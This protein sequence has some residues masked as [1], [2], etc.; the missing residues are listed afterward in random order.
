MAPLSGD[1]YYPDMTADQ[2]ENLLLLLVV[3]L[4]GL[5]LLWYVLPRPKAAMGLFLFGIAFVPVW[6]GGN[7]STLVTPHIALAGVC[8]LALL[9]GG[10]NDPRG[11]FLATGAGL[12]LRSFDLTL[13]VLA[14][15]AVGCYVIG[16][17]DLGQVYLIAVWGLM[18]L[19]GRLAARRFGLE[20]VSRVLVILLSVV[21]AL[22]LVEFLTGTNLWLDVTGNSTGVFRVWGD[23]QY[24]GS[25]VRAEGAFGHSIALGSSLAIG[26]VLTTATRW[27]TW[28]Q[29]TL[30]ALMSLALVTTF[31]RTAF[32][33]A[34]L[35]LVLVVLCSRRRITR[36]I[37]VSLAAF[38]A[39]AV[40]LGLLATSDAFSENSEL[41][42]D[43]ALYRLWLWD[44]IPGLR[45]IGRSDL[46]HRTTDG[47][48]SVGTFRSI[49]SAVLLHALSNGWI[50]ALILCVAFAVAAIRLLARGGD[51][52]LIAVVAQI[53]A[54]FT[55]AL[56]T[57]YAHLLWFT[58]GL[59]VTGLGPYR[60][61][62]PK[63]AD[64]KPVAVRD[65]IGAVT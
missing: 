47:S 52:A 23:Q 16:V 35:G 19:T 37:R 51:A 38:T 12:Q 61:A 14:V 55:V 4:V 50:P 49:D 2:L 28:V 54:F 27:R 9:L 15:L 63:S 31:S 36:S 65:E 46:M 8:L 18:Y 25:Y 6:L 26:M 39:V 44:L 10:R 53:P 24:R 21:S 30:I 33:S 22:A 60:A 43:A 58:V 1:H 29:L 5:I 57:Q 48:A 40:P 45:A 59:A 62:L 41:S 3:A 20:R 7:L 42:T 34:G 56:I 13:I 32:V 17:V 64:L 11:P